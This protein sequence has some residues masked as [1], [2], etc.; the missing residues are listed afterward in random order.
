MGT[1]FKSKPWFYEEIDETEHTKRIGKVFK[2][3]EYLLRRHKVLQ[4]PDYE[5]K[6]ET[7][8]TAKIVLNNVKSFIT[9]HAAFCVGQPISISGDKDVVSRYNLL[10]KQGGYSKTDYQIATDLYTYGNAFEYPY[11][12]N[13]IIRSHIIANEDAY[14]VYNEDYEYT[15]F[16]EYWRDISNGGHKYANVYYPKRVDRY[17]DNKLLES[18]IN[19]TGLPIHYSAMTKS[20]YPQFGEGI[21]EDLVPLMDQIEYLLSKIDDTTTTLLLNPLAVVS[22][23]RIDESIPK[24]ICGVNLNLEEGELKYPEIHLDYNTINMLLNKYIEF[25]FSKAGIPSVIMG[26]S[27]VSNLSEV[28]LKMLF[29]QMENMAR[30]TTVSMKDG[31][32]KRLAY[33]RKLLKT[34]DIKLSDEAFDTLDVNFNFSRPID[35]KSLMEELQIQRKMGCISRHTVIDKSPHTVDTA[36]EIKRIEEENTAPKNNS[37]DQILTDSKK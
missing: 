32:L 14:P 30:E 7:Y 21:M 3:R 16:I 17:R 27:N 37:S 11:I 15:H 13:G 18:K 10:Y 20:E 35:T 28:S 26:Q 34:Q 9:S 29:F 23:T 36:E 1:L 2:I 12:D 33:I 24:D 5:W 6:G 19:S 31:I 8:Q 25:L 22:G 4:R